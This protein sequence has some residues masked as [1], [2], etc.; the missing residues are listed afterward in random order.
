MIDRDTEVEGGR[1]SAE[2]VEDDQLSRGARIGASTIG[3]LL[4]GAGGTAVFLTD[5]Q[6]GCVAL[7]LAGAVFLLMVFGGMPLHSLGFG[8]A[9][10]RFARRRRDDAVRNAIESTPDQAP[11]VLSELEAVAPPSRPDRTVQVLSERVYGEAIAHRINRFLPA[12]S[13]LR[14]GAPVG[15]RRRRAD[16]VVETNGRVDVVIEAHY[17]KHGNPVPTALVQEMMAVSEVSGAPVLL[18]SNARLTNGARNYLESLGA[19]ASVRF[20]RWADEWDDDD[21]RRAWSALVSDG[22]S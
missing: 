4:L 18:V 8:E 17:G 13:L 3:A 6:A 16:F 15:P 20:V 10:L 9:N 7:I 22:N 2:A 21:L 1:E 19:D 5:N 12:T 11:Q 14:A